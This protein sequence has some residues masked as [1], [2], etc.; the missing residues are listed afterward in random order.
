MNKKDNSV[1]K[2]QT[3]VPDYLLKDATVS[4]DNPP[5]KTQS[6]GT[7]KKRKALS[8]KADPKQSPNHKKFRKN[9]F[10]PKRFLILDKEKD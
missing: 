6:K 2:M 7:G 1:I 8:G 10:F 3:T 9:T 5:S 4:K